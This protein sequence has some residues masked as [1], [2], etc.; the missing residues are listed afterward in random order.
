MSVKQINGFIWED[1]PGLFE[2]SGFIHRRYEKLI[3]AEALMR[4]GL[5]Q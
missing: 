4:M 2:S 1:L 3:E 5:Q